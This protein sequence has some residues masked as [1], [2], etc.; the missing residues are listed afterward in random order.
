[1]IGIEWDVA[2]S[3]TT[4][5]GTLNF[6]VFPGLI[7]DP[8]SC[9]A[10]K[11]LRAPV[12]PIPQGDG[13]IIHRRFQN[14]YVYKIATQAFESNTAIACA[15]DARSMGEELGRHVFAM[16]NAPGRYCWSPSGYGDNRA[17]DQARW[18][19]GVTQSIGTGGVYQYEFEI[20]SPFPYAIDLT[21]TTPTISG[22]GSI[23]NNGNTDFYPVVQIQGPSTGF[24]VISD[25][26]L[27]GIFYD[28][29]RAGALTIPG[30]QYAEWDTF[31]GTIY[32]NGDGADMSAGINPDLSNLAGPFRLI[33]GVNYLESNGASS[34]FLMNNAWC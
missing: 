4:N 10:T 33:P 2:A 18:F 5:A 32:L 6:N 19:T 8:H 12:D 22:G 29:T 24:S 34:V 14:G 1:M 9:S 23:T 27:E 21:Q 26:L 15:A 30:G 7:L 13:D 3:L 31:K 25:T 20:D 17:L 28:S 11:L 16:L